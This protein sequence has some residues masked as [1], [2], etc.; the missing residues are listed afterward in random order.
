MAVRA[1]TL[2]TKEQLTDLQWRFLKG[3]SLPET[4]EAF[5]L[6]ND[7]NGTNKELW[8]RHRETIIDEH[9]K[10]FPRHTSAAVVAVF[11][12]KIA[13]WHV[14]GLPL[15]WHITRVTN[16]AWRNWHAGLRVFERRTLFRLWAS[17][18]LDMRNPT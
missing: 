6:E 2:K 3:K 11:R 7:L 9:V 8:S 4:M 13:A 18:E 12:A 16:A 17:A 1:K 15:R 14:S 10:E 5:I